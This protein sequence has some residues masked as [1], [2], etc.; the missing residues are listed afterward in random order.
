MK[1]RVFE[2][3]PKNTA[4]TNKQATRNDESGLLRSNLRYWARFV[5]ILA[6]LA[7]DS[8]DVARFCSILSIRI[9]VDENLADFHEMLKMYLPSHANFV[10]KRDKKPFK[11][12]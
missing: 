7:A 2:A 8:S 3:R 9:Y 12:G 10:R 4:P 11:P 5:K 6:I 1:R